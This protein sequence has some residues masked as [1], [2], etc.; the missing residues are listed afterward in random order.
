MRSRLVLCIIEKASDAL[1][2]PSLNSISIYRIDMEH[3][4]YTSNAIV[5]LCAHQGCYK[6]S[7]TL[8][9]C[10]SHYRRYKKHGSSNSF[11]E[12]KYESECISCLSS[13]KSIN[14]D[15][16]YCSQLCKSRGFRGVTLDN[17]NA[18]NNLIEIN[19][20]RALLLRSIKIIK[21]EKENKIRK[22][23]QLEKQNIRLNKA[24]NVCMECGNEF[25]RFLSGTRKFC[26]KICSSKAAKSYESTK[27]R[28]RISYAKRRDR[29]KGQKVENV[30]PFVV[31]DRDSWTCQICR[32]ETPK[33]L[34]GTNDDRAPQLDHVIPL[35]KGGMHSY[36]NTQCLCRK[37]NIF[38]GDKIYV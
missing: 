9:F 4:N 1:T 22:E 16:K 26:T 19:R 25:V 30:D 12:K 21:K 13:F 14:Q 3:Q 8:S 38:K 35:A 37:C 7:R 32:I 33:Y 31:F 36:A 28:K 24:T 18:R 23:K 27:R 29:L 6:P 20:L 2:S 17:V 11:R 5:K 34:R 15:Q 10:D